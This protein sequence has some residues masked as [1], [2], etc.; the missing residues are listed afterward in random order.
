[1][2]N[3]YSGHRDLAEPARSRLLGCIAALI[4]DRFG[5][6]IVKRY[7]NELAVARGG[8]ATRG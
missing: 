4:D 7:L 8:R 3:T 2:L 1:V 5:G 6:S